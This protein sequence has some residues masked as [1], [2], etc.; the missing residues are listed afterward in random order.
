[1]NWHWLEISGFIIFMFLA[2][3]SLAE[4]GLNI[5]AD[6]KEEKLELRI[7]ELERKLDLLSQQTT[8]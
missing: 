4:Y 1:M 5:E 3:V 2:P 7:Q 6:E 8:Q